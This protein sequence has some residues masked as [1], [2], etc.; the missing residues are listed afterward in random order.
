MT[1][2]IKSEDANHKWYVVDATDLVLGRLASKV[3]RVIRGKE[4]AVF[5]PNM[6]AGDFV[7]VINAEKVKVTGK[8]ETLKTY[9]HHSGYPGGL[10]TRSFQDLIV[11]KPEYVIESAVQGMLPK[12]RLGRK[13]VKKLKVYRGAQHPHSAQKPEVLSL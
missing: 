11:N 1:R 5:T 13:L 9:S 6:D 4:K 8:R 10:K 12:T 3:A 7:I 2:F